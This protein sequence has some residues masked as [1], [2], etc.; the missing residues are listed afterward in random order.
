M[1]LDWNI[2]PGQITTGE[3]DARLGPEDQAIRQLFAL[4]DEANYS[5]A[6]PRAADF[7]RWTD[8]V[9][10]RLQEQA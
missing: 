8:L 9:N 1:S 4:T 3:I 5:G 2:E 6:T 10:R 7:E